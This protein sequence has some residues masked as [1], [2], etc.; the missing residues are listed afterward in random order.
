MA[1]ISLMLSLYFAYLPWFNP[2]KYQNY[3]KN[4]RAKTRKNWLLFPHMITRSA[5]EKYPRL[6][7]WSARLISILAVL[8][9]IIG[10]IAGL[11]SP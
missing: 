1:T 8:T 11:F 4:W 2:Q 9:S 3:N 7:I 10:V 5:F 6:E